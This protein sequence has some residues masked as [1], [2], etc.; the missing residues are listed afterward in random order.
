[1]C[2]I[3]F[4][5]FLKVHNIIEHAYGLEDLQQD[6]ETLQQLESQGLL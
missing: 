6:E 2:R 3:E 5:D 4:E 1:M